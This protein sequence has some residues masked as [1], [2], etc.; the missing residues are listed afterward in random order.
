MLTRN[1]RVATHTHIRRLD[2]QLD[3]VV[4]H[5]LLA[6]DKLVANVGRAQANIV[7]IL[8]LL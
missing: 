8:A 4:Y 1:Q 7:G 3:E 5:A 2:I 6:H